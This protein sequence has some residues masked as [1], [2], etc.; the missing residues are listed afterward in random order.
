M[1]KELFLKKVKVVKSQM[2]A[3]DVSVILPF[4]NAESTL[5]AA[6]QCILNQ[7]FTNLELILVDNASTDDSSKIAGSFAD[8]RIRI[9]HETE[10][11]VVHAANAGLRSAK[12]K[13]IARMDADDLSSPDRLQKQV[14]EL[15]DDPE[16]GV[17]SGL[18]EPM[19]QPS[20]GFRNYLDW[21]NGVI[22]PAQIYLNQFVE[23]PIV[24]PSIMF[25]S[26]LVDKFGE[27]RQGDFP[28]DYEFFLR[29]ISEGVKMRKVDEAVLQWND[30]PSRLTRTS[31][32]YSE[33]AFNRIKSK[34]LVKWLKTNNPHHP[35]VWVWG[36]GKQARRKSS[37]L[38]THGAE[39][40][41]YIDVSEKERS[42]KLPVIHFSELGSPDRFIVSYVS[43]WG[44]R[45]EIRSFLSDK[46]WLDGK[47]FIL[48]G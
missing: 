46:G 13:Y 35:K 14:D 40:Q 1:T 33:E 23:Y 29:L 18:V 31:A 10:I 19:T 17:V 44:A 16:L 22:T 12:G 36:A 9:I 37:E 42:G 11:G 15:D 26:E 28:E 30:L 41:G 47:D 20:E 5:Q 39:I 24:N 25:R 2:A 6:I 38:R 45:N 32:A 43:N 27:Y 4:R 21:I 48:A 8:P 34:Y 7:T 3:I